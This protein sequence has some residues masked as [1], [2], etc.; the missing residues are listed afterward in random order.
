[1]YQHARIRQS[2]I[3]KQYFKIMSSSQRD[4]KKM[5]EK[6]VEGEDE[7]AWMDRRVGF[8]PNLSKGP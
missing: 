1:M 8:K 3:F 6:A 2:E 5:E 7:G 4:G